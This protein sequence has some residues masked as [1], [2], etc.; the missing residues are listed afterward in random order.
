MLKRILGFPLI[1]LV[2]ELVV[3]VALATAYAFAARG[4]HVPN[5][6]S[7]WITLA[8]LVGS[9][10]GIEWL[11]SRNEPGDV[12][13]ASKRVLSQLLL[14]ACV[15]GVLFSIVVLELFL[16][17][18][19]RIVAFHPTWELFS[20][21][22]VLLPAAAIEEITF[23]GVVFRLISEWA[24]PWVALAVSAALFGLMHSFNVGASWFSTLAIA[25][26]AGVLLAAAYV[27]TGNLWFPIGLHF[28]WNFFEGPVFG[29]SLSG[30]TISQTL[31]TAQISGP[32]I[33]TGGKF[34][35]EAGV[36]ALLTCLAL[37][38]ALLAYSL[39]KG[40]IQAPFA[41]R[42]TAA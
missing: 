34:G 18:D 3:F 36:P 39:R 32:A 11:V 15:G 33:L 13:F 41:K 37:A 4:L 40:R 25:L 21:G 29:T 8:L 42:L 12:G 38:T 22:L 1:R 17:G 28:A 2:V 20:I 5:A 27:A 23:R 7:V 26:E 31:F 6:A 16:A 14:G 19:Y 10:L 24:G 30:G 35:P 9:V